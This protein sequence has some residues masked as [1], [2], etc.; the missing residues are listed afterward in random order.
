MTDP[1]KVNMVMDYALKSTGRLVQEMCGRMAS[2]SI[3]AEVGD[4]KAVTSQV[5][6]LQLLICNTMIALMETL[7]E[8]R[9]PIVAE[10]TPVLGMDGKPIKFVKVYE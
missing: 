4:D 10:S 8:L 2:I 3:D 6:D 5:E 9:G 1:L 7:G